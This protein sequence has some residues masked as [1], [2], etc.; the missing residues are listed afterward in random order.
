MIISI[1]VHSCN[2]PHLSKG[3]EGFD[4]VLKGFEGFCEI[5]PKMREVADF[6]H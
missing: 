6:S 1:Y 4:G 2:P 5:I 3:G